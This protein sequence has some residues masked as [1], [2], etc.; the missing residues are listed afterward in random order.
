MKSRFEADLSHSQ[1]AYRFAIAS[2]PSSRAEGVE[3]A[4]VNGFTFEKRSQIDSMVIEFGW[5][6]FAR[7][8]GCLEAYLQKTLKLALRRDFTID[9]WLEVN[10]V[11]VPEKYLQG[12]AVYRR[13]RNSL[14]HDDGTSFDGPPDTEIHL[15]PE[16]MEN[17]FCLFVWIANTA[18]AKK[19]QS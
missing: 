8:E 15:L 18:E 19:S 4:T 9:K 13:I 11:I 17:F 10:S 1:A 6:F 16:H 2:L 3:R 5:A 12:M 7:Y 14:H